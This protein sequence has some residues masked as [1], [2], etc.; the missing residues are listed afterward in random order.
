[1]RLER[2]EGFSGGKCAC[3]SLPHPQKP[4]AGAPSLIMGTGGAGQLRVSAAE[5]RE[6]RAEGAE[7]GQDLG[8]QE[9]L[10]CLT[11]SYL[12][13]LSVVPR[14]PLQAGEVGGGEGERG[15][16]TIVPPEGKQEET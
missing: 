11:P 5:R 12:Q 14:P 9:I 3:S 7:G 8:T 4:E 13:A 10:P 6:E 16:G 2:G 1:M 15:P